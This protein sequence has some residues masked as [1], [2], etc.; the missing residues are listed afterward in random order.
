MYVCIRG[1]DSFLKKDNISREGDDWGLVTECLM[2]AGY[3]YFRC[4]KNNF[5]LLFWKFYIVVL[6]PPLRV[7]PWAVARP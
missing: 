7:A 1:V 2:E 5:F 3:L 6:A 4:K